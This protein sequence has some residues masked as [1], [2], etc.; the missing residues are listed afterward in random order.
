MQSQA[1]DVDRRRVQ[2]AMRIAALAARGD[3][4]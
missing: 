2:I 3:L 4:D 1:R